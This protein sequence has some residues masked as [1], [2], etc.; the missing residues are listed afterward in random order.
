MGGEHSAEA[1]AYLWI[2]LG[3][4]SVQPSSSVVGPVASTLAFFAG[5]AFPV[6]PAS[7]CL[8]AI[9]RIVEWWRE[10]PRTAAAALMVVGEPRWTIRRAD[11]A[12]VSGAAADVSVGRSVAHAKHS[13]QCALA[14]W[15]LITRT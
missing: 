12:Q 13:M 8:G 15:K 6:S 1:Q 14:R 4:T 11:T 7:F 5:L 9:A 3:G 10:P 2:R